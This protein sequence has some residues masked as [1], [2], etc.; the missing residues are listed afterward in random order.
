MGAEHIS[1]TSVAVGTPG[2][3][4]QSHAVCAVSSGWRYP[5]MGSPSSDFRLWVFPAAAQWWGLAGEERTNG[6]YFP[7]VCI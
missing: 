3:P 2:S 4:S 1:S 7:M 5:P 6:A